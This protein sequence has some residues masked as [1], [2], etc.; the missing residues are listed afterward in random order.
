[1]DEIIRIEAMRREGLEIPVVVL[2]E[3]ELARIPF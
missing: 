1:M 3:E 2:T